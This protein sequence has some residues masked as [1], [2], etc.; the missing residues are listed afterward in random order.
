MAY[1]HTLRRIAMEKQLSKTNSR[2]MCKHC[3]MMSLAGRE[4]LTGITKGKW[5]PLICV[6][7]SPQTTPW[8]VTVY[9]KH[10]QLWYILLLKMQF[11]QGENHLAHC[12]LLA[13]PTNGT[14]FSWFQ[15]HDTVPTISELETLQMISC[16][17]VESLKSGCCSQNHIMSANCWRWM[18]AKTCRHM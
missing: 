5:L 16:F 4:G 18:F 14:R 6:N 7:P 8:L 12:Q 17:S 9:R 1:D 15:L 13:S 10:N 11:S 3:N 2:S